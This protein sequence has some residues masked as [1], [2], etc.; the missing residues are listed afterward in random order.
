M[1]VVRENSLLQEQQPPEHPRG[2]TH[3]RVFLTA[4]SASRVIGAGPPTPVHTAAL[5]WEFIT[6]CFIWVRAEHTHGVES[7]QRI[8]K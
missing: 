7:M 6:G 5:Y 3:G 1:L 4:S 2:L 8:Y